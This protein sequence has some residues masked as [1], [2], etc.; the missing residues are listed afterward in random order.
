MK[1]SYLMFLCISMREWL[2]LSPSL[3]LYSLSSSPSLHQTLSLSLFL[4]LAL[5]FLCPLPLL[6]LPLFG[7]TE[8]MPSKKSRTT[9][10][11]PTRVPFSSCPPKHF[12]F[13]AQLMRILKKA[14]MHVFHGKSAENYSSQGKR[15]RSL[16]ARSPNDRASPRKH[17]DVSRKACLFLPGCARPSFDPQ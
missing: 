17:D 12:L 13:S 9:A 15:L 1:I 16:L 6:L 10:G 5:L 8:V 3:F 11:M 4:P 2:S 14:W 7:M